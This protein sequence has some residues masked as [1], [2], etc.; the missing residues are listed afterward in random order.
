M[1]RPLNVSLVVVSRRRPA[2]LRRLLVS[3]RFLQYP[4]FEVLVVSD[5]NPTS[6][7][8]PV[9]GVD[10]IKYVPFDKPNISA[11]R[12]KGI[13][14]ARG[15]IVA[16]CDDDAVPEP[17]WLTHLIAAFDNPEVGAADGYVRGRNGI[18][19]QWKASRFDRYGNQSAF[20]LEGEEPV[21]LAGDA[22][23]GIK[24]EGTNCAF[25]RELLYKLGGFDENY[26]Y[27]LD[28]TD[29]NYRI[30]LAGWKT[31][32][33]PLA[34]VH[35]GFAGNTSR[36]GGRVPRDLRQIGASKAYF[37]QKHGSAD[38]YASEIDGFFQAQ[39]KRLTEYMLIGKIEPFDV[40]RLL[41]TLETGISE[42]RKREKQ[43][44]PFGAA[45]KEGGFR[46]FP[47]NNQHIDF[48]AV[49][50]RPLQWV[51]VRHAVAELVDKGVSVTVFRFSLTTRFHKMTF[52]P[53]GYWIQTGG[54]FGRSNR[55]GGLFQIGTLQKRA[56]KEKARLAKIRPLRKMASTKRQFRETA[57]EEL[58]A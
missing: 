35:H 48:A 7:M 34:Q 38:K 45:M 51:R 20:N 57:T 58:Q 56:A 14:F 31:A 4:E 39:R 43:P 5:T 2:E 25:R 54:I 28:E 15:D 12:N 16:F 23:S 24:T 36:T 41:G 29:L 30:G 11:A 10:R 47:E 9:H 50:C 1:K 19:Y 22:V 40:G 49:V 52:S 46:R 17:T 53:K 37:V 3:L 26:H 13:E 8:P 27:F 33:V 44:N 18:S 42:G 32:L 6:L 21:I 55:Q